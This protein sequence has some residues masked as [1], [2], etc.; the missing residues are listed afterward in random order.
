MSC[1]V[2]LFGQLKKAPDTVLKRELFMK[3]LN[4]TECAI[5]SGGIFS[6]FVAGLMGAEI[7]SVLYPLSEIPGDEDLSRSEKVLRGC[8]LGAIGAPLLVFLFMSF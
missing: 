1:I 7:G 4:M 8:G 6:Y 3:E 2:L 5:V